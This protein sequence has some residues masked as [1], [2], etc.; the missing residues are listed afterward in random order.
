M[1]VIVYEV[2]KHLSTRIAVF[3][4]Q[5]H[6]KKVLLIPVAVGAPNYMIAAGAITLFTMNLTADSLQQKYPGKL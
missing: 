3:M 2:Q 5:L 4:I 1:V 6:T